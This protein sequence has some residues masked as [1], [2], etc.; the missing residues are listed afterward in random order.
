MLKFK[1]LAPNKYH[2]P[3]AAHLA[4][5]GRKECGSGARLGGVT[6][7]MNHAACPP[8]DP[9]LKSKT[10]TPNTHDRKLHIWL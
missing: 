5:S 6:E 7:W 1:I 10:L 4:M 8:C 9:M 2:M 3:Y